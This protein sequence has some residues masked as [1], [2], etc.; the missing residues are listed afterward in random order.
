M[1]RLSN[2][3]SKSDFFLKIELNRNRFFGWHFFD[4]DS[5]LYWRRQ[6]TAASSK[7]DSWAVAKSAEYA[8]LIIRIAYRS[9]RAVLSP[10]TAASRCRVATP[11]S[12]PPLYHWRNLSSPL[13]MCY[14]GGRPPA[15]DR[16][17][18]I[19]TSP[20]II[21]LCVVSE[22]LSANL[23]RHISSEYSREGGRTVSYTHL[24][25]PTILRV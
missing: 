8:D 21:G 4:F 10:A 1:L 7:H 22:R 23:L 14:A 20:S 24:T 2:R 5:R 19:Y 18:L 12:H 9:G 6:R 17:Q 3:R 11:P 16:V 15:C 13:P 25:L